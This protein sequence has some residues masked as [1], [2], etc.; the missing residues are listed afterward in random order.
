MAGRPLPWPFRI[1]QTCNGS[2]IA[3][4]AE[5]FYDNVKLLLQEYSPFRQDEP[6]QAHITPDR[7]KG[8][9]KTP[10]N[11]LSWVLRAARRAGNL[12]VLNLPQDP[13][14]PR[15]HPKAMGG[16]RIKGRLTTN[17]TS[18][19]PDAHPHKRTSALAHNRSSA[20]AHERISPRTHKRRGCNNFSS[21]SS[22]V[23]RPPWSGGPGRPVKTAT[24]RGPNRGPSVPATF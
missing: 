22:Y 7:R 23:E 10:Y 17:K 3:P 4:A 16:P 8:G 5:G 6:V 19:R 12:R 9:R 18:P 14:P 20:L 21:R 13:A 1:M 11:R 24:T 15:L 2:N